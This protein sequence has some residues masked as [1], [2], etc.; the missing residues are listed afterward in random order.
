MHGK[1]YYMNSFKSLLEKG[2][3]QNNISEIHEENKYDIYFEGTEKLSD[4]AKYIEDIVFDDKNIGRKYYSVNKE[5]KYIEIFS[6]KKF[7]LLRIS[8]NITFLHLYDKNEEKEYNENKFIGFRYYNK[9]PA[10]K[11]SKFFTLINRFNTK[12]HI[13]EKVQSIKDINNKSFFDK[14]LNCFAIIDNIITEKYKDKE[15]IMNGE[16]FPEIIGYCHSLI[17][18][19]KI[20]N[21]I[22]LEPLIPEAFKPETLKENI[23]EFEPDITYVEPL[24]YNGHISLII[25]NEI[26][27]SRCN[28][29]LDMSRYH[30]NTSHFNTLI[31]PKKI[32]EKNSIYLKNPIQNYS[33]CCLWFYGEIDCMLNDENYTNFKSIYDNMQN[34]NIKFFIDVINLI[35]KKYYEINELVKY[36]QERSNETEKIDLNRLFI[37]GINN[38]SVHKDILFTQF[39]NI[40]NFFKSFSFFYP[41]Q[42]AKFLTNI[43]K[44]LEKFINFKNIL[45]INLRFYEMIKQESEVKIIMNLIKEEQEYIKKM[46]IELKKN[47]TIEFY[48][49]NISSYELYFIEDILKDKPMIFPISKDMQ[50]KM[51]KSDFNS[52]I[53]DFES[54]FVK[55]KNELERKYCIYSEED[56]IKQLNPLNEICFKIMNK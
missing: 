55:R 53:K 43:E 24:I 11:D 6:N 46:L 10:Q 14:D 44:K 50:E 51:A 34:S 48:K 17:T 31:F 41:S 56:I 22:F 47:Y 5:I 21:F 42:D 40:N 18:L 7:N 45:D 4:K 38:T 32:N 23:S 27:G 37:V 26:N 36:E 25:F 3:K 20:R 12:Y 52:F 16:T 30:I 29:I 33:S 28:L 35:G 54:D 2:E 1:D 9:S 13:L 8:P 39:I 19:N 15:H 49:N